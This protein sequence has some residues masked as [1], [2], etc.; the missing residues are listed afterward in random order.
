MPTSCPRQASASSESSM[1]DSAV[2]DTGFIGVL[3][4]AATAAQLP[5]PE[6]AREIARVLTEF[7][8]GRV[9]APERLALPLGENG[10]YLVM[11]A[12]DERLAISKLVTV[13]PDNPAAGRPAIQGTVSVSSALSGEQLFLLD[14]AA[15]TARRTAALSLLAAQRL[16]ATADDDVFIVG[17]GAQ[18][19]AHVEALA[20]GLGS[21]RVTIASRNRERAEVLAEYARKL[22]LE[23]RAVN[24]SSA[25]TSME[26]CRILVTA[27]SSPVP[28]L[29]VA[30][31]ED[32]IILAVGAFRPSMA[33]LAP[34]LVGRCTVFVDEL[35]AARG[36]AGD[37][38]QA[39]AAGAWD[40]S[41]ATEL[42]A[43]DAPPPRDRP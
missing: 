5:Y 43:I 17:S 22:G 7:S 27:T 18:A 11:P 41:S 35:E 33:E 36:G 23:G 15:V 2:P 32:C 1:P 12:S 21:R 42:A 37:L 39:A 24:S 29:P 6:L 16:G 34:E 25:T 28:V 20:E 9:A 8:A 3:N 13:L 40:W 14:G 10:T 38:I 31:P 19:R 4:A 26:A 30:V